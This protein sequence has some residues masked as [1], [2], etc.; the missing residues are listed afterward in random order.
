MCYA[1]GEMQRSHI[2]KLIKHALF[3][4][5]LSLLVISQFNWDVRQVNAQK[6]ATPVQI[7]W[8][9]GLGTGVDPAQ[10]TIE[11]QV[12]DDFNAGHPDIHLTLEVQ[13]SA[14]AA[15]ILR[16]EIANGVAPDI[17][18]PVGWSGANSFHGQYLDLTDLIG[19]TGFNTSIFDPLLLNIY[20]SVDEGQVALPFAV[21]PSALYYNPALFTSAGLY[22][23]PAHYGDQYQM[24]D[25]SM[26]VWSW[27]TLTQVAKLLTLDSSGKNATQAG[28][29]SSQIVQ[30]GFSFGWESHP[31]YWGS[32]WHSG[33][34]LHGT[35]GSYTA[36]IPAEWKAAWQW[37][38]NG[39]WGAQP[40]LPTG[41]IASSA[42]FDYGNTF[43]S[44]NVAILENP[45]WYLSGISDL[46]NAGGTFQFGAMPGYNGSV[47]GRLDADTFRILKASSHPGEAFTALTYLDTTGVDKL[48]VG[49]SGNPPAYNGALSAIT[50]KQAAWVSTQAANFSFV[51]S[52]SWNVLL[53]GL[54]Y[55][56]NPSAEAYMPNQLESWN[57]IQEFGDLLNNN[58]AVNLTAA[59][60]TLE[61]DLTT[62]F[63][64][65]YHLISGNI[66]VEG[67]TL[68]YHDGLDKTATSYSGGIYALPVSSGWSNTVTPSKS[69]YAFTP[70]F[71]SYSNV[72]TDIPDQDYTYAIIFRYLFI[73]LISHNSS[74]ATGIVNGNFE[75]GSTGW[76]EYSFQGYPI[77][78]TS[79]PGSVTAHSGSYAAWLGGSD[80]ENN[81]VQQQI[82]IPSSAQYLSYWLWIASL[83]TCGYDSG[84]VLINDTTVDEYWLCGSNDTGGWVKHTIDLNSYSGQSVTLKIFAQTDGSLNSNLFIDDVA[85]QASASASTGINN[86]APN[87][88]PAN[89]RDK[90]EI[91]IK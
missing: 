89:S 35:P 5:V 10:V 36:I 34:I 29:N 66:G 80:N 23:P 1:E 13:P 59:D 61:T 33:S 69:G 27:D 46:T 50:A 12:A 60:T 55:P 22:P 26:V 72:S 42:N 82:I 45:A 68:S 75:S 11:Q 64:T 51:T 43:G 71:L 74:T 31:N 18:G 16:A 78:T 21:Y 19:S 3:A 4:F 44:G 2:T 88:D 53:A 86:L 25:H 79:F 47:A 62:I 37:L 8:F 85:L 87:L 9:I 30:Y 91:P 17:V 56:D 76:T 84:G 28:F 57:R 54:N 15:G 83:D 24:P 81:Y 40:Y 41:P 65:T 52:N 32:Y 90:L 39:M 7:R 38:Y 70:P 77:I 67:V 48:I 14:T 49:S 58:T 63:N 6:S 73:P 20:K